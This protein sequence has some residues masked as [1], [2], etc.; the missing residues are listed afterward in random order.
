MRIS[1]YTNLLSLAPLAANA[2]AL[3]MNILFHCPKKSALVAIG[4]KMPNGI[5]QAVATNTFSLFLRLA[6]RQ[7]QIIDPKNTTPKT[8]PSSPVSSS[9]WT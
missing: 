8:N 4:Q 1:I 9:I 2:T 7:V 3:Q 6:L 5:T